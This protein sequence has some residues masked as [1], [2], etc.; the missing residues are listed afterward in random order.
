MPVSFA[1]RALRAAT[2]GAAALAAMA[3]LT[4]C[5]S[6]AS[7]Q[8]A[9]G[10]LGQELKGAHFTVGSKDFSE[11]IILGQITMQLLTAH[12]ATVTDKTNIKGSTNTRTALTSGDIDMYW[13][14]TGTG[15]VTYL[16][17]T[18][19]IPDPQQQYDAVAKEDLST[20]KIVWG[21]AAPL[22]NTYAF[23]IRKD[24]AAELGV[25]T[26]SDLEQLVATK[27]DQ[28]TFCIESEFSTRDD[29]WPGLQKAY[30]LNVPKNNVKLLDT[31]VIYSETAKGQTCNFGEVFATD[32]RIASLGLV[33][34][35][36]DKKFFPVYNAALTLRQDTDT[37]YPDIRK[38][39]DP[40]AAKLTTEVMQQLNAKVDAQGEEPATVAKDW[41]ASQ[42]VAK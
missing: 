34:L 16:K 17:H 28:A 13:E 40:I 7:G 14:Y 2:A 42:G 39:L 3:A 20:N 11:S 31:G 26:L 21:A 22:N 6:S 5:G 25:K 4:A 19:P 9:Q 29:G 35:T 41:L 12:G 32:G 10:S 8:A 38:I 33:V 24:K 27:P 18:T 30:S 36:D 37:K 1:P 23:A 15:W